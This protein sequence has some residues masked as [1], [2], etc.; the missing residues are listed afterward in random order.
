MIALGQRYAHVPCA[1]VDCRT[2]AWGVSVA[3]PAQFLGSEP[4]EETRGHAGFRSSDA[5]SEPRLA[6][7]PP[8]RGRR[9][10]LLAR[11][12]DYSRAAVGLLRIVALDRGRAEA[13]YREPPHQPRGRRAGGG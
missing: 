8:R 7:W 5:G 11:R 4:S 10:R 13:D 9:A 12:R 3:S 6:P 1:I 2:K